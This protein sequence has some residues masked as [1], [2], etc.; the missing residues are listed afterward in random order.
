MV[1]YIITGYETLDE[2]KGVDIGARAI[3]AWCQEVASRERCRGGIY[4]ASP[5]LFRLFDR[6]RT[7]VINAAP[8]IP[9]GFKNRTRTR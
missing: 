6:L 1:C 9:L 2:N 4:D 3:F 5:S 8:T 7:G